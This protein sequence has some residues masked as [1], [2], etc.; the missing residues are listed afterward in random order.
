MKKY[1]TLL[2]ILFSQV[3]MAQVD[4]DAT[5]ATQE[6]Y[7]KLDGISLSFRNNQKILIGQQNAFTEGKS[8]VKFNDHIGTPLRSDMHEVAGIHPA[9]FG[10]DF[11][12]IGHWNKNVIIDNIREVHRRGGVFTLSWHM[13]A[14]SLVNDGKGDGGFKDT[15][16]KVV[17]HILPGGHAHEKLK[18][19]L[20]KLV[21]FAQEISD[22]PIIFRPYHEHTGSWFWW[23]KKHCTKEEYIQLWRFT[24]DYLKSKGVHNML[25]AYSPNHIESD[26][27]ERYPGDE[28]VDILGT[29]MYFNNFIEDLWNFGPAKLSEWKHDVIWLLREADR[30]NKIPA[31]TEFGNQAIKIKKFWTDYFGWPLERAGVEQITGK[32]KL[33]KRGVAFILLWRNA[34]SST[35][36]HYFA[37]IPGHKQNP[38]F[39]SLLTK[40]IFQGID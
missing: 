6:L 27:L 16:T 4:R 22:I 35:G 33:P 17:K 24:V 13:H 10:I 30:R 32:N 8:W 5:S 20:D 40:G 29:D 37:P 14:H 26:Y 9:I 19:L 25:Y 39:M 3:L 1:L 38:N 21:V 12:E 2:T 7:Q 36:E 15:T 23:G 11:P 28:Y 34:Y 18:E 31:I